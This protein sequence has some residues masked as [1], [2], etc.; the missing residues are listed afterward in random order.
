MSRF[1]LEDKTVSACLSL[2]SMCA[3]WR[4]GDRRFKTSRGSHSGRK[5]VEQ[6]CISTCRHMWELLGPFLGNREHQ[7]RREMWALTEKMFC[8]L[9]QTGLHTGERQQGRRWPDP[10]TFFFFF[11][12]AGKVLICNSGLEKCLLKYLR[13][14]WVDFVLIFSRSCIALH[15]HTLDGCTT[16]MHEPRTWAFCCFL[17]VSENLAFWFHFQT[18]LEVATSLDFWLN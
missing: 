13:P 7:G 5:V 6:L 17:A 11:F 1:V 9:T 15:K 4:V 8:C 3:I 10:C 14:T 12:F 2:R 16:G 18:V